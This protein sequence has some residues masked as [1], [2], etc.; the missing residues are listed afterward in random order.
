MKKEKVKEEKI[1]KEKVKIGKKNILVVSLII[2][3]SILI[4]IFIKLDI[5]Q[6]EEDKFSNCKMIVESCITE[7]CKYYFLC[8]GEPKISDCKVYD[9]GEEYGVLIK[10]EGGE[11]LTS[12]K[13]KPNLEEAQKVVEKCKGEIKIIDKKCEN[14]SLNIDLEVETIGECEINAFLVDLGEKNY[15]QPSWTKSDSVFQLKVADTCS[16]VEVIAI[17]Q[18][19]VAIKKSLK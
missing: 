15:S 8:S 19:G 12:T 16:V 6:T 7:E 18:G 2:V 17:G 10:K 3:I 1:K 11:I 4:L 5:S 9:C 13:P 14:D